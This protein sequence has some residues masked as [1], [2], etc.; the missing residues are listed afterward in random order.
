[1][2]T[3]LYPGI[4]FSPQAQLTNNIGAA[5]TIIEVSDVS[6][7]PP[8]PN[9]A[10]IGTDEEGETILYTA[11]T[12]TALSGCQRGVEGEAKGWTAGE[13]IGRNFTAKD[14]ADLIAA[15]TEAYGAAEA[16]QG[17][18][19]TAGTVAASKQPKLTGQPGQVV[20]FGADG[21]AVAVQGWSSPNLLDDWYFPD[22][23]NQR[24]QTEY[25]AAGYT[26]DRWK[27]ESANGTVT[28]NNGS[29]TFS[30]NRANSSEFAAF[31]QILDYKELV[32]KVC[33][34]SL[35]AKGS[36]FIS[37]AANDAARLAVILTDEPTLY[38]IT[39][40]LATI[41]WLQN[42]SHY[43]IVADDLTS[44]T[45]EIEI[46]AVK[47]ELGPIQTLAHQD[48]AGNWVL[49]DP[50]P[51][52]AL[53]LTK[54]QRY[55]QV[56]NAGF[57]CRAT[58]TTSSA[59]TFLVPTSVTFRSYP[60]IAGIGILIVRKTNAEN[61]SGFSFSATNLGS[62]YIRITATKE[63]HGMTDAELFVTG[64]IVILDANL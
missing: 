63:N 2:N 64:G 44:L 25:T 43:R 15:A 55:Q 47:L 28:L 29:V 1:M 18:A 37:L 7:F 11:K 59:I 45:G 24:G 54:C 10:T 48:A 39:A 57:T 30:W 16:A 61:Q 27:N 22:P 40:P 26:I 20:G 8:A 46:F 51:N 41:S 9:L 49:N 34:W 36:G 5:D 52:K 19:A 35:L 53:E 42:R 17:A 38:S 50:P 23:V 58:I 12:E 3:T 62:G 31:V 56:L 6:A 32:G 60:A 14:H 21:A 4:P 13:L 33:T